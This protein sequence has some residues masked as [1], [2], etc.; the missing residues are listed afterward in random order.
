MTKSW[1]HV[2]SPMC[3]QLFM[4][5]CGHSYFLKSPF[6]MEQRYVWKHNYLFQSTWEHYDSWMYTFKGL[7]HSAMNSSGFCFTIFSE[8]TIS[9]LPIYIEAY[10]LLPNFGPISKMANWDK[11]SFRMTRPFIC[12]WRIVRDGTLAL[13]AHTYKMAPNQGF[14]SSATYLHLGKAQGTYLELW[15]EFIGFNHYWNVHF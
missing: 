14:I 9:V 2:L 3:R 15:P 1:K 10:F 8:H 11:P 13:S 12:E 5:N 6:F 7:S 4:V